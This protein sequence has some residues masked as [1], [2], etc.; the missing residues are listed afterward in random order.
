MDTRKKLL[1]EDK[2]RHSINVSTC[3]APGIYTTIYT[4][5]YKAM[6][7]SV[8]MKNKLGSPAKRGA[9][10]EWRGRDID[11]DSICQPRPRDREPFVRALRALLLY[12][13]VGEISVRAHRVLRAFL[14][15]LKPRDIF[16][17][18]RIQARCARSYYS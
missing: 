14:L 7:V 15:E 5:V 6:R 8:C 2:H 4:G 16:V 1:E 9:S 13:K 11:Q 12:L 10:I 17:V 3:K 18:G